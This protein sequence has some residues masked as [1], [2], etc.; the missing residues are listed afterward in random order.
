MGSTIRARLS[1]LN[2]SVDHRHKALAAFGFIIAS[3]G[4]WIVNVSADPPP[5]VQTRTSIGVNIDSLDGLTETT[6]DCGQDG[7]HVTDN[8]D[9]TLFIENVTPGQIVCRITTRYVGP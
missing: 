6:I 7:G 5:P 9:G 4:L 8:G 3:V 2:G 1:R